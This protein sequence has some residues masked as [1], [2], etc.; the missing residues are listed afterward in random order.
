MNS[1]NF[2]IVAHLNNID[3]EIVKACTLNELKIPKIIHN[4]LPSNF[5]VKD[6]EYCLKFG[7]CF[8]K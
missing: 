5:L 4:H 6:C 1:L 2:N 7:N 3:H 8:S